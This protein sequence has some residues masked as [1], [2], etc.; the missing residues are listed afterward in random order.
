VEQFV[1]AMVD[2][3]CETGC[4]TLIDCDG[5]YLNAH[6]WDS[7]LLQGF[8]YLRVEGVDLGYV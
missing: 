8:G 5:G 4:N 1:L 6:L 3:C 7:L 2:V